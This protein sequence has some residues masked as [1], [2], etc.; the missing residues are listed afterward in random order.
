[1]NHGV[2]IP[3]LRSRPAALYHRPLYAFVRPLFLLRAQLSIMSSHTRGMV[4]YH[5]I[6]LLVV[7]RCDLFPFSFASCTF[8]RVQYHHNV[9]PTCNMYRVNFRR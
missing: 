1:M 6:V 8:A 4:Y 3:V 5:P 7:G 2:V 9:L